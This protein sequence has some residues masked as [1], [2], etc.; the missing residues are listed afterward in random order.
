MKRR[1]GG[2]AAT[3][4]SSTVWPPAGPKYILIKLQGSAASLRQASQAEGTRLDDTGQGVPVGAGPGLCSLRPSV[5][6][7]TAGGML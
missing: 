1:A 6:V 2:R 5:T 7:E 4:G 3:G